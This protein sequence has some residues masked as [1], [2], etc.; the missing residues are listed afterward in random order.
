MGKTWLLKEFGTRHFE[1]V[2]YVSLD[3]DAVARSYFD[4]DLDAH[5]IIASLSL[6]LN[7]DIVPEKT[8][9]IL[10]EIQACPKAITALKYFC[11]TPLDMP[12]QRRGRC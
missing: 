6:Q 9:I 10:D 7:M 12:L 4:M 2:A 8:L 5:R 1:S 11:G 3:N